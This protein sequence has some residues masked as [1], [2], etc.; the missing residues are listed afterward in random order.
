LT[1]NVDCFQRRKGEA[2]GGDTAVVC[3][4]RAPVRRS[5]ARNPRGKS[6]GG[7]PGGEEEDRREKEALGSPSTTNSSRD[8]CRYAGL[9]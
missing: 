9:R 5:Y 4:G 1:L 8:A 7:A 2:A 3:F 6:Q